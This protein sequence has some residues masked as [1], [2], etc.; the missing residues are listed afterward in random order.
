MISLQIPLIKYHVEHR[1]ISNN[2]FYF[3][4]IPEYFC[5]VKLWLHHFIKSIAFEN[6]SFHETYDDAHC[7][8]VG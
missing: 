1:Q 5:G 6:Q 7:F 2:G 3:K 4:N 8:T